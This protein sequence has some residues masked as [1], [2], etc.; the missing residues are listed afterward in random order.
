MSIRYRIQDTN[1]CH[2]A[3]ITYVVMCGL[4]LCSFFLFLSIL[5]DPILFLVF[6]HSMC[7]RDTRSDRF[8][9]IV[10]LLGMHQ[11]MQFA[12]FHFFY[13]SLY[14]YSYACREYVLINMCLVYNIILY[15]MV[16]SSQISHIMQNFR[17]KKNI[18]CA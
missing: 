6:F 9:N 10:Y 8:N 7:E 14:E 1:L 3:I 15:I 12:V 17:K 4:C 18:I 16:T 2:K 5:F 13:N 11:R